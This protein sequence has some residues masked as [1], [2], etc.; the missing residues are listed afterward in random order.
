MRKLFILGCVAL[1][2][3]RDAELDKA[4][5]EFRKAV[6]EL[7]AKSVR[8]TAER[9]AE[10]DQKA[11]VDILLDGYG[12][13][14]TIVKKHWDEKVRTLREKEA[15]GDFKI[16][17]KTNPPTIPASDVKKYEAYVAAEKAGRDIEAK[18]MSLEAARRGIVAA[19]GHF[20]SDASVKELLTELSGGAA[21]QRRAGVAEALG[22]M[23]AAGIPAALA[24]VVKKDSEP[25]VRIAAMDALRELKA[26][27]PEVTAALVEQ[28]KSDFWQVKVTAAATIKALQLKDAT[29]AVVEAIAK[30]DGRLRMEFND[31]LV[32]LTGVDKHGDAGAWKAWW[33][34]N[35]DA[36]QKG[37]Y[38]A[39]PGEGP[40]GE[41]RNGTTFYGIPVLSKNVV[42]CLDR[43]GAMLEP[44]E[45]D[46]PQDVATGGGGNGPDIKKEGNRKI[47]IARWQLKR[48]LAMMPDGAEF[49]IIF[50]NHEWV[51]LS[52][53]MLKLSVSTRKTAFEFID[54]LDPVGGTNIYDPLEKGFSFATAGAMGEKLAKMGVDT[55]F[56]LTDGL[57]NSGQVPLPADI[58]VKV[59]EL[60]KTKKVKINTVGVFSSAKGPLL[61]NMPNE[62][63]E[64]GKLL[65]QLA[66]DS[67]GKYTSA[68]AGAPGMKDAAGAGKKKP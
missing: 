31:T 48:T 7:N 44:S 50:F 19:L 24:E 43:S 36:V 68:G 63:D 45:W 47:D 3:A 25:Q 64:G 59:R 37:T 40:G 17:M 55:I 62:A 52:N 60:N 4:K 61:P 33:D 11:A 26:N 29:E 27:A 20:K 41:P 22:Q 10:T 9:L 58:L 32:G 53:S 12:T 51:I 5:A 18:I 2:A 65:K 66:E 49:N 16:D 8:E 34:S 67:G 1:V 21:W 30:A 15:N 54:K 39:K 38:V 35:K 28:L 46:I 23:S 57:P 14:A 6:A 13:L 56:F 42:F